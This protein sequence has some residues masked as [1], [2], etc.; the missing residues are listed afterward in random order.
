MKSK[1]MV[2]T[3]AAAISL[4]L[5]PRSGSAASL[6]D[7]MRRLDKLEQENAELRQQIR[8]RAPA[9]AAAPAPAAAAA[10]PP[11]DLEKF[12]GNPVYHAGVA[13]SPASKPPL[14]TVA[15]KPIITK[16]FGVPLVDNT[17]VTL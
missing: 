12:K 16:A 2:G 10:P 7:V 8:K 4:A 9:R 17:T 1:L 15:G 13:T 6:D 14:L 5:L 11:T 3:A